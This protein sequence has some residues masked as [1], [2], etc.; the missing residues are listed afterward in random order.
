MD[1]SEYQ[2]ILVS[3]MRPSAWQLKLGWNWITQQKWSQA[4]LH[5][6]QHG[7]KKKRIKV[8]QWSTQMLRWDLVGAADL[9]E[10]KLHW[11]EEWD[12]IVPQWCE[13]LITSNRKW[14]LQVTGNQINY[15]FFYCY[16]NNEC[17][18]CVSQLRLY[19]PYLRAGKYQTINSIY[20]FIYLF[21]PCLDTQNCIIERLCVLIFYNHCI[22]CC[23][24]LLPKVCFH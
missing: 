12:K 13:R 18:I 6:Q 23:R 19:L 2:S 3:N 9:N 24:Y 15:F 20:P 16:I 1:F 10:Q 21:M 4:H 14:L 5:L 22:L 8:L 7:W 17:A 11:K